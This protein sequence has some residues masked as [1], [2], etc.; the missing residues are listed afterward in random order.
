MIGD[1][2]E[3]LIVEQYVPGVEVAAPSIGARVDA[4]QCYRVS[5]CFKAIG[6]Q[7]VCPNAPLIGTLN[8]EDL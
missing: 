4:D 1:C 2:P 6:V 8:D 3:P 5:G 7:A